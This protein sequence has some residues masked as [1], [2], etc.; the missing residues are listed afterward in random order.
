P[1]G[2]YFRAGTGGG[3]NMWHIYLPGGAWCGTAAQCVARSKTLYGTST[4]YPTDP[5]PGVALRPPFDGIL[6]SNSTINP[7]FYNWNLVRLIYCDGGGYSGT[8]GRLEV[9]TN[10]TAI[11][12]DGWNIV[13]AV[14]EDSKDRMDGYS[15]RNGVKNIAA[16]HKPSWPPCQDGERERGGGG[17][18][19]GK[20]A[21]RS[22][23][24][25]HKPSWPDRQDG[26][27]LPEERGSGGGGES[28]P[29]LEESR[30]IRRGSLC[31]RV[32]IVGGV[33]R[34]ARQEGGERGGWGERRVGR[35]MVG[36]EVVGRE[37]VGREVV[38]REEGGERGGGERRGPPGYYFRAGTGGGKNM[39]HIYLP[40]GAWC[41][42]AA[43][44]VAR[45]KTLFGTSTLYPTDPAPNA[46]LRPPFN[47]ILSS[48]STINPP[49]YNWNLVRLI[50]CDGGGYSGTAGRLEVGTN[51]TAIYLDGWSIVQA[52]IE[53]LQSKRGIKS[54]SQ[55][56]L[57]GS[58][59]GG[60]AVVALCDRIAAAFPWAPT[61]CIS[62]S[63]FFIDSKDRVGGYTW[64]N[65]VK[66]IVAMHKPSWPACQ[67]G[68][69][70]N[71]QWNRPN[72]RAVTVEQYLCL[73]VL[74]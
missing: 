1:P 49:F 57:S 24:A 15:W 20:L 2:Y 11:Y 13:Q 30:R 35:E 17:V 62:D 72:W 10:G 55:I 29:Q 68:L 36:R 38:G 8:A 59:A 50:Y 65:G 26:W 4:L 44:C 39:W 48:N 58:S 52:V 19:G 54:A 56:L 32:I 28:H 41:G 7:P 21:K 63:G 12:L 31:K 40:G 14:I 3:K 45:S 53:D 47:G 5:A 16:M 23:A 34:S 46:A 61:K 9:G 69:P 33:A 22:I 70:E 18:V 67:D 73:G 71:D 66:S 37:V 27:G 6:S 42:T 25:L 51:G 74:R 64:R 43:Q 60:Q